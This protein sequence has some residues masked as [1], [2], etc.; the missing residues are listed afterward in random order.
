MDG[1]R[2][3][4]GIGGMGGWVGAPIYY[5]ID[6]RA[7]SGE[8]RMG[9]GEKVGK[10]RAAAS[11]SQPD[12]TFKLYKRNKFTK[13]IVTL[14]WHSNDMFHYIFKAEFVVIRP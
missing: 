12:G 4:D 8:Y 2:E 13:R 10:R 3:E 9:E 7:I 6:H 14:T 11:S 5:C 1:G